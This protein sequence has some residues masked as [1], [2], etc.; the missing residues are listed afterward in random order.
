MYGLDLSS[1]RLSGEIP[2]EIGNLHNIRSLNLSSN[3]LTSSIPDSISKLMDLESLDLSNNKLDGNISPQ[4]ASLDSLG[5]FNVSFNNLS[6]EIPINGH[7]LTFGEMS[8]IGNAHLC[9][10][11]I[12]KSCNSFPEQ[13]KEEEEE[14]GDGV[15][16]MSYINSLI[17]SPHEVRNLESWSDDPKSD[18]CLWERVNCSD[19]IGGHVV[20]LSLN[21]I[22]PYTVMDMISLNLSFLHSFPQLQS[23]DFSF[24]AIN[25]L[26]DPIHGYKSFQRLEKLRTLDLS[27]NNLNNSVLPFL[28]AARSLRTLNLRSNTLEGVPPLNELANMTELRVLVLELNR[29]ISSF[30]VQ[31]L[32]NLRELEILDLR[33]TGI[34]NIEAYDGLRMTKLKTLY[35]SSNEFSEAA[36]LKGLENLVELKVLSLA[37]NYFNHTRSIEVLKDMPK[38][39][40]LDL[41]SNRFSDLNGNH[42]GAV[43]PSSLQV[44]SLQGNQLSLTAKGYSNIC[45]LTKLRELDLRYNAL[46]NLPYC[47]C[48]LSRLRTLDLSDNQLN[49]NLSSFVS[50][51]PSALEY[52]SLLG[53]YFSG[54]F[55]FSSMVNRTRLTV[56]KLSSEFGS[57]PYNISKIK[58]L[59]SLD[60]SSNRLDGHVPPQLADLDSLGVFNVSCNNLSGE[61]PFNGHLVT[62]DEKSYI[63]N[64]H[65]CGL[66]IN[67]SCNPVPEPSASKQA[68]EEEEEG[69]GVIDMV[70]FYWTCGAVYISTLLALSAFLCIDSRWSREW[71]YRVDLLVHHFQRFKDRFL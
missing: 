6:G 23:L 9:G 69:D 42:E 36:Q 33:S 55:L 67:K 53:N 11:P 43:F 29:L 8:Y 40:E 68:K 58:H 50:G 21:E 4:L 48:N 41:S 46:T 15:I 57:I 54:S 39:Q 38:L 52:L 17:P 64:A 5:Y 2:V 71:F 70:W 35:L 61:I 44:L 19:A 13:A 49:G 45:A 66:P 14:E 34:T 32:I 16:D 7:L 3:R 28:T 47:L 30:S 27:Y 10:L 24:N 56:F 31:G 25:H 20:D 12:N 1:N 51:L 22:M 18:C 60:L 63:G 65:L 26:F 37:G 62:F 59:E